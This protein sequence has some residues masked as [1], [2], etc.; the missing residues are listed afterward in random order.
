[1]TLTMAPARVG[2]LDDRRDVRLD[3]G[4]AA[5]LERAD[6]DDHVELGRAVGE[7][8]LRLEDLGRGRGGCRAG[9]R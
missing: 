1:M 5:G 2:D 3:V 7:R 6:L 4:V 8:L 9:S